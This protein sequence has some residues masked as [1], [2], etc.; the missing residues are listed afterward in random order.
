MGCDVCGDWGVHVGELCALWR[1]APSEEGLFLLWCVLPI[2]VSAIWCA[3]NG[4]L[5]AS[6]HVISAQLE[7][8]RKWKM[9]LK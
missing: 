2:I 3:E 4:I 9:V 6:I 1:E 5:E 7:R 8:E